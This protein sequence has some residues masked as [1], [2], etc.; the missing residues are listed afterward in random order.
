MTAFGCL[1]A[2]DWHMPSTV[3]WRAALF[4][5][6]TDFPAHAFHGVFFRVTRSCQVCESS[7][8]IG[9]GTVDRIRILVVPCWTGR[10]MLLNWLMPW[11]STDSQSSAYPAV[12]PARWPVPGRCP[13]A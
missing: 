1:M 13:I 7:R 2:D 6:F 8:R 12:A 3:I 4:F 10:S 11:M 5:C 9:P